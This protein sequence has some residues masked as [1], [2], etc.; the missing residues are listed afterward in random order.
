M[1]S[2]CLP[3]GFLS[4]ELQRSLAEQQFGIAS[5]EIVPSSG[6]LSATARVTLL[7]GDS[8]LVSLS[9]RGYQASP[10]SFVIITISPPE[11]PIWSVLIILTETQIDK[12]DEFE[13]TGIGQHDAG[14][15]ELIEQ[16]LQSVSKMYE[17]NR[18]QCLIS[19]LEKWMSW[20][21]QV[22]PAVHFGA[23]LRSWQDRF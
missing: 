20:W 16:L 17:Q 13:S 1:D 2:E 6:S 23:W 18:Q 3:E 7:E 15:F 11:S 19:R 22:C 21:I 4:K 14:I 9:P 10:I 8:L 12:G 5:Y